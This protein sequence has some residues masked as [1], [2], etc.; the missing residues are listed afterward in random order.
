MVR[1][2]IVK[3]MKLGLKRLGIFV[4]AL[5]LVVVSIFALGDAYIF[6]RRRL[7]I[8]I[9]II[10]YILIANVLFLLLVFSFYRA[11]RWIAQG[12]KDARGEE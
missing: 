1:F 5:V 10:F 12:F 2:P 6:P 11:V 7:L 3:N 8:P 9:E 4:T